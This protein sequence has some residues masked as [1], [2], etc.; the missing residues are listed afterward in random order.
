MA[1]RYSQ[2]VSGANY[3][4]ESFKDMSVVPIALRQRHDNALAAQ[5]DMLLQ[6]NNIQVR[7]EDRDYYNQKRDE[8]TT[9]INNLTNKI[10]TIGAGDSNLL[11][12]FR[13]MK[14]NYNK[15]VSL[16]GGLGQASDL[17][18]RIDKTRANYMEFGVKQ[19]FSPE[20]TEKNFEVE[21]NK[22]NQTNPANKLGSEGFAYGEFNPTYAPKQILPT[23]YLKNIQPL[24]GEISKEVAWSNFTP[25]QNPQTGEISFQQNSGAT[26]SKENLQRLDSVQKA[27]NTEMMN[28][29]SGLRQS[30]RFSRPGIPEADIV[31]QFLS[32]ADTWIDVM[33]IEATKQVNQAEPPK[34]SA[35]DGSGGKT[36]KDGSDE[37]ANLISTPT[38]AEV[39][40]GK[41]IV[42]I[43]DG[44]QIKQFE[45]TEKSRP[46]TEAESAKKTQLI[47]QQNRVNEA[48]K[49]PSTV[50]EINRNLS[51]TDILPRG[52]SNN[53]QGYK[54][55]IQDKQNEFNQWK[56]SDTYKR[57]LETLTSN[58]GQNSKINS[59]GLQQMQR[60]EQERLNEIQGYKDVLNEAYKTSI[61]TND[62]K[63]SKLYSIGP[64]EA[65]KKTMDT[66]NANAND[67]SQNFPTLLENSGG[68]FI[69]PGETELRD[70]NSE[71]MENLKS[72]FTNGQIQFNGL[73]IVDMGSTGSSQL[74][75][76]YKK[77]TGDKASS[78]MIAIDYDNK[79]PDTNVLD[80]WL[81][82]MQ[83]TLNPQGQAVIQSI[84][85]NKQLKSLAVD[86]QKFYKEG[87][88]SSQSETIKKLS[89][90]VNNKYANIPEYKQANY[91]KAPDR[92]LNMVLN[93]KGYYDLYIKDSKSKNAEVYSLPAKSWFQK[94]FAKNY[95]DRVS[96]VTDPTK[97]TNVNDRK[98][99][100]REMKD[101]AEL[102]SSPD[103]LIQ[104][105]NGSN[106]YQ[107]L[108]Q[109]YINSLNNNQTNVNMQYE[110]T[111]QFYRD[112]GG[113]KISHKNKKR[114]L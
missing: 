37:P 97:A 45:E 100:I 66:F 50:A 76:K 110:L 16:S 82:E 65:G 87:F 103:N 113:M 61:P 44:S 77:S 104:I 90:Q 73:D 54:K 28:P 68:K 43:S 36:K 48:L 19:G 8:I 46:L 112:M 51:K 41:N 58:T 27:I 49:S 101:F 72:S 52:Y 86:S 34:F 108:R 62:L 81:I 10:N 114:L 32:E 42:D 85:D 26:L 59:T 1:N 94:Q 111:L 20:T 12:E 83:K 6:L 67:Y 95:A 31:K 47:L 92:D 11:G 80:T 71:E 89:T 25:V 64:G 105:D 33:G 14:R 35:G 74:I 102:Y 15:E 88:S 70:S 23:E 57:D 60:F 79:S 18:S 40:E 55:L 93:E 98:S 96:N 56:N 3:A 21:Y 78:G 69:L 106:Q 24:I 7:D 63:Y 22:Y 13:N 107:K 30:L 9:N 39:F 91:I 53:I 99:F 29:D 17:K 75:F 4:P 5:D 84:V 2:Y 109:D 38:G